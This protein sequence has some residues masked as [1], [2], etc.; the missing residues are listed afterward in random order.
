MKGYKQKELKTAGRLREL[1]KLEK[2]LTEK[3]SQQAEKENGLYVKI[4]GLMDQLKEVKEEN[5]G[6]KKDV[7]EKD[8][9]VSGLLSHLFLHN[10]FEMCY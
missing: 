6:L 4:S 10:T 8:E 9:K 1:E 3:V 2:E 7:Y 5:E